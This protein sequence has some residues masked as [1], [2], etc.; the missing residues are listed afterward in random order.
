VLQDV[1]Q[2]YL[3]QFVTGSTSNAEIQVIPVDLF[4]GF[5]C[6][7]SAGISTN[8]AAHTGVCVPGLKEM[9][10]NGIFPLRTNLPIDVCLQARNQ[11]NE[12]G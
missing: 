5:T 4:A 11:R 2:G 8:N 12:E 1:Q 9:P 6:F 10:G 7:H 3:A